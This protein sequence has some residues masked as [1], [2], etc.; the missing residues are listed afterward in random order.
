MKKMG[1][2]YKTLGNMTYKK[3]HLKIKIKIFF[4]ND[5]YGYDYMLISLCLKIKNLLHY[6]IRREL[7]SIKT[8]YFIALML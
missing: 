7:H 2:A 3:K 1:K 8:S 4:L 5:M 6:L